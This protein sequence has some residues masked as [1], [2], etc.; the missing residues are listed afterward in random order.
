VSELAGGL[1]ILSVGVTYG[2]DVFFALVGRKA[3]A[4]SSE[5]AVADVMGHIHEVADAR[6]PFVGALGI[7]ATVVFLVLAGLGTMA[8]T[9]GIVAFVVQLIFLV[10]YNVYS[11]PIN[12]QLRQAVR[13]GKV[14]VETR[15]LQ[16]RWDR[17]VVWRAFLL[18]IAMVCLLIAINSI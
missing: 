2:T 15:Q 13:A 8:S 6:M 9:L 14:L 18:L 3:L 4:G 10:L 16:E 11:K 17:V 12:V 5:G 7:V 1:A